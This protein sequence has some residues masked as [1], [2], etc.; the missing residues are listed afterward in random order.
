MFATLPAPMDTEDT[1][2][3]TMP[4]LAALKGMFA[5]KKHADTI[6]VCLN[7]RKRHASSGM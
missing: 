3:L 4:I 6:L 1:E 2:V 7:G 5:D